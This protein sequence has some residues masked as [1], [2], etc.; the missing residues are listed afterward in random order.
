MRFLLSC[1]LTLSLFATSMGHAKSS[2]PI[3]EPFNPER[4]QL[5]TYLVS[6][7]LASRHFS[8]KRLDDAMSLKI[9][10]LYLRQLDPRKRFLL[11]SDV[12]ELEVFRSRIDDELKKGRISLPD[13]GRRLLDT[14]IREVNA[15]IDPILD[16]GFDFARKETL[17]TDPKKLNFVADHAEL[18]ERWRLTLKMQV[19]DSFFEAVEDRK[20]EAEKKAEKQT[21]KKQDAA[22]AAFRPAPLPDP[23]KHPDLMKEAIRKV[24]S[25]SHRAMQRLQDQTRQDHY[26]RY[27]DA[28]AR[29]FDPHSTYMPPTSK[30][31][32]D[33]QMSGSLEG[34]G[35]LLREDEGLIKVVRIMPGSPAEKQGQ[36]QAEDTILGVSEK[37]GELV[38]ITEMRIREAVKL[39]RGPK[40]SQVVLQV[41]KPDGGKMNITI[42][43]DIVQ[44]EETWAKSALLKTATGTPIGYILVPS[45]YRDF[46][47]AKGT[48]GR[49]VTDDVG[50]LVQDLKRKGI[51]GLILDLR[52]NGGGALKDAVSIAGMFIPEGPVVQ[53][54]EGDGEIEVHEDENKGVDYDGPI[55]VLVNQFS[56]SASEIVAAALQDYGRAVVIGSQHTHG[57]GTV[58]VMLD[59]NRYLPMFRARKNISDLGALKMTIQKFYRIN[60]GSTQFRGVTPDL[61]VPS[62]L[63]HLESGEQ[64]MD[65]ALPWDQVSPV[66]FKV[67]QGERLNLAQVKRKGGAWVAN[68]PSFQNIKRESDKAKARALQTV[69]VVAAGDMWVERQDLERARSEAKAAGFVEAPEDGEEDTG[70]DGKKKKLE[71]T[72]SRDPYVQLSLELFGNAAK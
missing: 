22:K 16:A 14:R 47:A 49:N 45:F 5:I 31:D 46:N 25:S 10:D 66:P 54:K 56:A 43:R 33:I 34:I 57:K 17:E 48:E 50:K 7:Q 30:E 58:Q 8:Q 67:W 20:K 61:I 42:T 60:G 44:L 70:K 62:M 23:A 32:F 1:V 18:R 4:N 37:G 12:K 65:Y 68:S 27:F 28:V 59:M 26:D 40:G 19:L 63:D 9:F 39:I 38:D 3:T 21:G 51:K 13:L 11:Q 64:Y 52:N 29:A 35:A 41:R 72:L 6:Q 36:L 71:E 24:R 2:K 53:V 55:I 69:V 15:L